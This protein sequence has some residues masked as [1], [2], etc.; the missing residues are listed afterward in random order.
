MVTARDDCGLASVRL[1]N[2][3]VLIS[4]GHTNSLPGTTTDRG[5]VL[6]N[7]SGRHTVDLGTLP[8][9]PW[10]GFEVHLAVRSHLRR[11]GLKDKPLA[12]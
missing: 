10:A 7:R 2:G 5:A 4:G 11:E 6:L 1:Q 3:H 8:G 12:R 9:S